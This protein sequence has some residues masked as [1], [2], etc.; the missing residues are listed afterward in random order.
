MIRLCVVLGRT[1]EEVE[2]MPSK[3]LSEFIAYDNVFGLPDPWLAHGIQCSTM[4]NVW[5][6]SGGYKPQDFIPRKKKK[7]TAKQ[8]FAAL[9]AFARGTTGNNR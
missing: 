1:I 4:A 2:A 8:M 6:K 3:H 7:K 9:K 5:S